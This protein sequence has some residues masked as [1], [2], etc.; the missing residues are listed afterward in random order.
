MIKILCAVI[1]LLMLVV[2]VYGYNGQDDFYS[3]MK[4]IN[5]QHA[6]ETVR[7]PDV[8]IKAYTPDVKAFEV[9]FTAEELESMTEYSK[10][11]GSASRLTY[12]EAED[13]ADLIFRVLKDCYGA[14]FYFGGDEAFE[15]AKENVLSD[16]KDAGARLSVGIL[17]ESLKRNL[18]FVKDG[19]FRIGNE[20]VLEKAVYYSNE[21][22]AFFKDE[23]GYYVEEDGKRSYVSMVDGS[24]EIE[25][26]MKR[27][28]NDKGML[29]YKI[30]MLS[31]DVRGM[32]EVVLNNRIKKF[33]LVPPKLENYTDNGTYYS[34]YKVNGVPVISISSFMHEHD[35]RRFV[36]SAETV[37]NSKVS[38]L[39]VRGNCGGMSKYVIDW[40]DIYDPVLSKYATG[41]VHAYRMSRA[42]DYLKYKNLGEY[43]SDQETEQLLNNYRSGSNGWGISEASA[44]VRSEN[45]NL[46]FVLVDN[47]TF[48]A[49]EWLIAA[50]RNKDNVIFV[51]TNSG[52][53][54]MS[55]SSI[56]VVL[57]DSR[58]NIQCG[59]GLGF[60]YDD[61]VF[62]EETGFSPDIWINDDVMQHTLD[63]ISYYG[64]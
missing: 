30:G 28:I 9:G 18:S 31:T 50:L 51:G 45:S 56:N 44:F 27:S 64:L 41:N 53:G 62:T 24:H 47:Y 60:Y 4:M 61:T 13:D 55:D 22:T 48:S 1:S 42:A 23:K 35:G 37:K 11:R 43:F 33:V 58:I 26:Y 19:H 3:E 40:L 38:V 12:E 5:E 10:F 59:T 2:P 20:T 15:R 49:G 6:L 52:G 17:R 57:P 25:K 39:D 16:C 29:V 36:K 14:Y 46:L 54:L 32:V 21:E 34:D 7:I 8:D 63:M